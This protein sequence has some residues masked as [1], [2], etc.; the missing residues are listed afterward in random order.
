MWNCAG[1]EVRTGVLPKALESGW[2]R[3]VAGSLRKPDSI[4]YPL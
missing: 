1:R 3:E 4:P 2:A